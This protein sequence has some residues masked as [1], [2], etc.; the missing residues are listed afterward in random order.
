MVDIKSRGEPSQSNFSLLNTKRLRDD[1][2]GTTVKDILRGHN[3]DLNDLQDTQQH[4]KDI[5]R[6]VHSFQKHV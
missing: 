5:F 4:T 3:L 1:A 6:E 2:V